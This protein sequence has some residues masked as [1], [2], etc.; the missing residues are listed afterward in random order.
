MSKKEDNT[1]AF[2]KQR[3]AEGEQLAK[4]PFATAESI[5]EEI[6]PEVT[7]WY[8]ASINPV[9]NGTYQVVVTEEDVN[10][11]FPGNVIDGTWN[12]TA[13]DVA[14]VKW[15]G[16]A[17]EPKQETIP[18]SKERVY[19]PGELIAIEEHGGKK[20]EIRQPSAEFSKSFPGVRDMIEIK[21]PNEVKQD[22]RSI[23]ERA[24]AKHGLPNQLGAKGWINETQNF[25]YDDKPIA[26]AEDGLKGWLYVERDDDGD[27]EPSWSNIDELAAV[28]RAMIEDT[29]DDET[30]LNV[31]VVNPGPDDWEIRSVTIHN[32]EA[33]GK[34]WD[35]EIDM[36]EDEF[37]EIVKKVMIENGEIDEPEED[38]EIDTDD[39]DVNT[40]L[41][42]YCADMGGEQRFSYGY[43]V[44]YM[45]FDDGFKMG[46]TI[47]DGELYVHYYDGKD[48]TKDTVFE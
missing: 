42:S 6:E 17:S 44:T 28:A 38:E 10:W 15:R 16:L 4:W 11:P 31:D 35:Y 30:S 36:D 41:W 19:A 5:A 47:K 14:V 12:G 9:R 43:R 45:E 32:D 7:E 33:D 37:W 3:P 18:E 22:W 46:M 25:Y 23:L 34:S 40:F 8:P 20:Y 39:I 21:D 2:P 24:V 13:W 1:V 27:G 26:T 48:V 29:N